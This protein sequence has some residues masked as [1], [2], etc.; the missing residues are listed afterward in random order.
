MLVG[1]NVFLG[2]V[3][4]SDVSRQPISDLAKAEFPLANGLGNETV[5][6][7]GLKFEIKAVDPQ[8][9]IRSGKADP[10]V[11]VEK[12]VVVGKRFHV[13]GSF[14]KKIFIVAGLWTEDGGL[15]ETAIAK[16][17]NA[18]KFFD[19]LPV[20]FDNFRD[21]QISPLRHLFCEKFMELAV[22]VR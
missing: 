13:S 8:E 20:H 21:C 11:P 19:E 17:V 22:L 6:S 15:Q 14:V 1:T 4:R 2:S 9:R 3:E 7:E 5:G 16:P 10:L 18:T 12:S